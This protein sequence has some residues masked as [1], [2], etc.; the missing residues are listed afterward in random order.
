MKNDNTN[1]TAQDQ[2]THGVSILAVALNIIAMA[3]MAVP[4][5]DCE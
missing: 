1:E 4:E 5:P 3:S 2:D